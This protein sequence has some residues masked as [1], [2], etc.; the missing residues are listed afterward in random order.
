MNVTQKELESIRVIVGDYVFRPK[1]VRRITI[2]NSILIDVATDSSHCVCEYEEKEPA[3]IKNVIFNPPATIVFWTDNTKTV[4]KCQD[5]EMFDPEK[6]ITMAFFKKMS[7]NKGSYFN[8][9]KKWADKYEVSA[10]IDYSKT[11]INIDTPTDTA[12][13]LKDLIDERI[14]HYLGKDDSECQST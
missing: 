1:D 3:K 11:L 12:S 9:I 8:D 4:V 5:D 14:A 2:D 10:G 6:G 13:T 7:G